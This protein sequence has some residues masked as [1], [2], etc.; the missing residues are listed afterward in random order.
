MIQFAFEMLLMLSFG[1][2]LFIAARAL[3]RVKEDTTV[4]V[5]RTL[6]ERFVMSDVPH[7]VDTAL[8]G[9]M[10]KFFRKMKV[11]LLKFDN[12]LTHRLKDL[13]AEANGKPKIDF[14]EITAFDD[15]AVENR[16]D[17]GNT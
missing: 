2:V 1:G 11:H 9:F 10:G 17:L 6:I 16:D 4:V 5:K 15:V 3:P 7:R 13:N 12:Y 8:N 14:S